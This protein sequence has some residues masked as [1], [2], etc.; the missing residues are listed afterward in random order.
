MKPRL[1][2]GSSTESLS[3]AYAAQEELDHDLEVTVWTQSVFDLS[4]GTLETL[5]RS[6]DE[7]DAALF[8]FSPDD[9]TNMRGT[10]V[11]SVRDNVI[12][13]FGLFMGK[14]G[15]ERCFFLIPS[16]RD[17]HLPTDLLGITPGKYNPDRQDGRL[18]AAVG[19]TC[20]Q[21][22]TVMRKLGPLM[23]AATVGSASTTN[24]VPV[25]VERQPEAV[26]KLVSD[27]GLVEKVKREV[28]VIQQMPSE[29]QM[30]D[31]ER[32]S[33]AMVG[34]LA[35][36]ALAFLN[37][38]GEGEQKAYLEDKFPKYAR[39]IRKYAD[40]VSRIL[41]LSPVLQNE[42]TAPANGVQLELMFAGI[43]QPLTELPKRP[44][45]PERP[46]VFNSL[47]HNYAASLINSYLPP[48]AHARRESEPFKLGTDS[49]EWRIK[50]LQHKRPFEFEPISVL[51]LNIPKKKTTL[52]IPYL[53]HA[54]E[55]IEP[56]QGKIAIELT[57]RPIEWN[58]FLKQDAEK[59][60][61][62]DGEDEDDD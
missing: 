39:R 8:V 46:S 45:K 21:I 37:H 47:G 29:E 14:L 43:A 42:G 12:L 27:K 7:F 5:M 62:D 22:R 40:E 16:G 58:D 44:T 35:P 61:G 56:V 60:E 18:R 41:W 1:F 10:T 13:E 28:L 11:K 50:H 30:I 36:S 57:P 26:L 34:R 54:A 38:V 3:V 15:R 17:M 31:N 9:E 2:I 53:V 33:M 51:L 24:P 49:V 25:K 20:N 19:P 55:F 48:F 52:E 23:K 59:Q 32:R 4:S 6:L